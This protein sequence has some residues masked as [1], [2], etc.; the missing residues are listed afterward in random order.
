MPNLMKSL[1]RQTLLAAAISISLAPIA[2]AREPFPSRPIKIIVNVSAGGLVD[3]TTRALAQHMSEYLKQPVIID[4]RAGADGMIAAKAVKAAPAD[5]Y[6]LLAGTGTIAQQMAMRTDPGYD[7]VKDFTGI[8]SMGRASYLMVVGREQPDKTAGDFIARAKVNSGKLSYASA[9]VGSVPHLAAERFARQAGIR[10]MHVP[11]K[12]NAAAAADVMSGRVDMI[13]EGYP[14]AQGRVKAG[15]VRVLAVTGTSRIPALP[16]VPTLSEQGL[17]NFTIFGW[18]CL[19]APAGTPKEV[20]QTLAEA[21]RVAKAHPA[22]RERFRADGTEDLDMTP[23]KFNEF[24]AQE[25]GLS[26]KLLTDLG[27]EKQ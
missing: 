6:T 9:G 16:Q 23:E 3:V 7:L 1:F 12:G 26:H 17:K 13:F 22:I 14:N 4:N 15:Q 19:L 8:G 10:M 24:L 18:L 27:I 20:V 11:Y 21:L 25:V 5:G 2:Y